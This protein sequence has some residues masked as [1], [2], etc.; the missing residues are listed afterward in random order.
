MKVMSSILCLFLGFLSTNALAQ[1]TVS[2]SVIEFSPTEKLQ[3]IEIL[4][5]GDYKIYLDMSLAEIQN[6]ESASPVRQ[7]LS[8][9]RVAPVL[10][11]PRQ[12]LVLPG[13]RKR[14]RIIMREAATEQDRIFRLTVKPYT[15][16]LNI[17]QSASTEK[18]SAIKVLV[19]YDLL[20][21]SRP[22]SIQPDVTTVRTDNS[23]KFV[24]SGNT[25]VLLRRI[26]Q[27][28]SA[29]NDCEELQPNRLY[30]GETY[31]IE[32]PK[33]GPAAQYPVEVWRSVSLDNAYDTY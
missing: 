22:E 32:L 23:I 11:S 20:L 12:M 7:E 2:R 8:D 19:G 30:A 6:P 18:A 31:Q 13:Q 4:N 3:D 17:E 33:P 24:N 21:I 1:I 5:T 9:P 25:N 26:R 28:D 10:V 27:C 16:K 14:L 15:G 29:G